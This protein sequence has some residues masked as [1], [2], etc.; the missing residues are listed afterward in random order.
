VVDYLSDALQLTARTNGALVPTGTLVAWNERQA[1]H[2]PFAASSVP[3]VLQPSHNL[4][5]WQA[6]VTLPVGTQSHILTDSGVTG[7]SARFFRVSGLTGP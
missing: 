5:D 7:Q 2:L 1:G 4:H 3:V 6:V